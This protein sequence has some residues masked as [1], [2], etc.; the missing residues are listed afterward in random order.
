MR[1]SILP[2]K[3]FATYHHLRKRLHEIKPDIVHTHSSKAGIIGRWAAHRAGVPRI[4][5]TIHGLAFTAS[6]IAIVNH[7]YKMLRTPRRPVTDKIVCVADA[8]RRSIPRR[9]HRPARTI[10]HR[11]QRHGDRAVSA[12]AR[13][14]RTLRRRLGITDEHIVVGTIARL[15]HL[16]GHD[17]LLDIAP[18][19]V[20]AIPQSALP[21]GRRR[22]APQRIRSAASGAMG[23]P[24]SFHPHRPGPPDEVPRTHQRDGHSRPSLPARRLRPRTPAGSLCRP[25]R[26]HLRHRRAKEGV[27]DGKSGF[28]L[29][30]FDKRKLSASI[31]TLA[32]HPDQRRRMGITGR[33]FALQ[34]FAA[35]TMVRAWKKSTERRLRMLRMIEKRWPAVLLLPCF[36]CVMAAGPASVTST[37]QPTTDAAPFPQSL[38]HHTPTPPWTRNWPPS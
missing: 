20:P 7:A 30:P 3:D 2:L 37:S 27:L 8:M 4:I 34:R 23:L 32:A 9:R 18:H 15:F 13:V 10:R 33:E 38:G 6:T 35:S 31:A 12:S 29:P 19:S 11:L 17:D 5:H 1:R 24:R 21:L 36:L 16:K 25:S 22:P 28:V 26:H 14:P